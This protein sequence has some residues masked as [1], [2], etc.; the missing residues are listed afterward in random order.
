VQKREEEK[1]GRQV[2]KSKRQPMKQEKREKSR[3]PKQVCCGGKKTIPPG[4]G[5]LVHYQ[6]GLL[7]L[8][9]KSCLTL[10]N[11]LDCSLPGCFVHGISQ[12]R[13]LEWVAISSSR[14]SSPPRDRIHIFCIGWRI[15]YH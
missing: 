10:C 2:G 14:V 11:P 15:L 1:G 6:P 13:T 12:A 9:A 4:S 7:L 5:A 3:E 8:V